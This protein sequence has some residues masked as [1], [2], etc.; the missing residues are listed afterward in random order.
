M[1]EP[2]SMNAH[3]LEI[4]DYTKSTKKLMPTKMNETAR[5]SDLDIDL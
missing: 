3:I 5:S 4:M 2:L 1:V